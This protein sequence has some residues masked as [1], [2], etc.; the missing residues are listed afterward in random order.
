MRVPA[1]RILSA[2]LTT[3]LC[4]AIAA[5][6][7][8]SSGELVDPGGPLPGAAPERQPITDLGRPRSYYLAGAEPLGAGE[9]RIIALGTG[10]PQL[11]KGQASSCWYVELGNGE[12][13]FFDM[14]TGCTANLAMLEQP[15]DRFSKVFLSHLHSD[16]IGDL[17]D[18]LVG[19]WQNGRS[20]P[21]EVWGPS[22]TRAEL[23]TRAA[24]EHVL[25][26]FLWDYTSK[27]GRT[28]MAAY[29]IDVHEF[30]Y[31]KT[32]VV[33][34][35]DGVTVTAWPAVHAI[36]GAVS[37]SIEWRGL[38][39]AYSGDTVPNKW[40]VENAKDSDVIVHD[41]SDPIEVLIEQRQWPPEA[42][43]LIATSAH[44]QPELAG[45]IFGMLAPRMAVC[46]HFVNNVWNG[47]KL[48]HAVRQTYG[49]PLAV[50]EDMMVWNVTPEDILVRR[51]VGGPYMAALTRSR[52]TPD[53]RER[54]EPSA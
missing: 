47:Q 39:L 29:A 2:T 30:D 31:A 34:R 33:Y 40:F 45:R 12:S 32:Q 52:A 11:Q 22:G 38:K 49:G 1:K 10:M 17:G 4:I 42:A 15:W 43:W 13:L 9:M 6:V 23:G 24:I 18:L 53:Q 54:V 35:K 50:A 26:M 41:C 48:Y 14:G 5:A 36:D 25:G 51:V 27:K 7:Q 19:G 37:Y 3:A 44:T 20:I 16:H 28:P 21:L 46:T 8:Q